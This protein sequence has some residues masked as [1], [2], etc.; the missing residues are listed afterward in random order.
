MRLLFT[1]KL[2]L[3]PAIVA[4]G[5]GL[6]QILM[7]QTQAKNPSIFIKP[8]MSVSFYE[9]RYNKQVAAW[10]LRQINQEL[11]VIDDP[12]SNQVLQQLTA[13]MNGLVRT[14]PLY[15]QIIISD[16]QINAF[17]AAG[18]LIGM[19]TGTIVT[20]DSLGEVASVLAHE[21]AHISQK[22]Y[23][24]NLDN[25]GQTVAL[26]L[27]GL[28]ASLVAAKAGS[29][30][31]ALAVMAGSQTLAAENFT[32]HSRE[33]EKEADR[34][35]MQILAGAGFDAA[36]MPRFFLKLHQ[37]TSLNQDKN[38]FIPSFIQTHP[39]SLD[40]LS[41][42]TELAKNY[43]PPSMINQQRQQYLFDQWRW[44]LKYLSGQASQVE[45]EAAA[46]NSLGA[47]LA[48]I[49]Y[50]ADRHQYRQ[51]NDWLA[52]GDLDGA[53]TLVCLTQAHVLAKQRQ[54]AQAVA[55]LSPCQAVYPERRD[56]RLVLA[57]YYLH[58]E[59][60]R[61]ALNLITPFV[62]EDSHDL[63]AWDLSYRAYALLANQAMTELAQNTATIHT[64]RA[65]AYLALWKA[66]YEQALKIN[67]QAQKV[68]HQNPKTQGLAALLEKDK[69]TIVQARDFKPL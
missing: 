44:R 63:K 38:A 33:H 32:A 8:S 61:E 4:F 11:P 56:L 37:Q 5:L 19:N 57:D 9:Q 34:V 17:A 43:Q 10:S 22:H 46:K 24:H 45:L 14:G 31:A 54:Y 42:S 62:K 3:K 39:F 2:Y 53:D 64:L 16:Q 41:E 52:Q 18:G 30:D 15:G 7:A 51:A 60:P 26:Q 55:T 6:L 28:L 48:L 25:R 1:K 29:G 67:A 12:W 66:D 50:L 58:L 68:S 27:G 40:R 69:L 49:A 20:A 59:K 23:E 36:A 47:R 21:I 35:G 65:N 13:Q